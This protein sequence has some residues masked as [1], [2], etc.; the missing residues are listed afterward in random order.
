MKRYRLFQNI[1]LLTAMSFALVSCFKDELVGS[2]VNSRSN[3]IG[4]GIS[5]V[6][7]AD[8]TPL[9]RATQYADSALLML[10]RG[11]ADTLYLHA[12]SENNISALDT[13]VATRGVPVNSSNFS[14][15]CK[16]FSVSAFTPTEDYYMKN[17]KVDNLAN[18][19][20]S[21][22]EEHFWPEDEEMTL[23]F[24]A[25]A[26]AV[27]GEN[28][29]FAEDDIQ[30]KPSDSNGKIMSFD[31]TVP[32][33][34]ESVTNAAELQ[35]D[36]MFAYSSQNKK[37]TDPAT[38]SVP[39]KFYH[40]LAGVKFVAK[41]ITGGTVKSIT[42][43]NL[44]GTGTC[45]YTFTTGSDEPSIVWTDLDGQDRSFSQEFNV[46]VTNQQ[47]GE[48]DITDKNPETTFMMIPQN[49]ENAI[50]EILFNDGKTDYTLT[51]K[52]F[53]PS[54]LST[55]GDDDL[56]TWDAGKIYTYAISTESIN[57]T[58]VF[59][60]TPSITLPLGTTTGQYTVTSYR[61]RKGDPS[62]REAV[63]WK[64]ENT[65]YSEKDKENGSSV[66][67]TLDKILSDF[68]YQDENPSETEKS[69]S[70]EVTT[71]TLK[72]TYDGDLTL[73]RNTQRGSADSPYD[74]STH[75]EKGSDIAQTTANCYVVSAAGTYQLPLVYGN[76]IK[77]GSNNSAA[78]QGFKDYLDRAISSPRIT[79]ANNA[80][81]VWSDGFF[82][83]KDIHLDA[84]KQNLVFT[85]DSNYMQQ[86]NAVLAVR[87][88]NN[89][90]MWSWHIWVT[91]RPVYTK[92]HTLQDLF[93]SSN[94]YVLMQCNLGWVDGKMVYYNQRD[95]T[96]RFTQAGSGETAE[97]KV[98]QEGATFDYKDVG[99]TYYQWGRKDPLVALKNWD[100]YRYEDYRLHETGDPDYVYQVETG[101]TTIGNAIQ[102]PNVF[103]TRGTAGGADWNNEH[104]TTLWNARDNGGTLASITSVKTIYD[105]SPRGFKVP[106]PRAF[107]IFVGGNTGDGSSSS[108]K[109]ELNGHIYED[110]VHNKYRVYPRANQYK[111]EEIPLTATGQ[112]AD[113]VG[114]P[115]YEEYGPLKS[116]VGG[117]WSL[118]GVYYWTCVPKNTTSAYTLVIRKDY[119]SG[120]EVYS[121]G[122]VGT[123]TMA[124]PVRP[125]RE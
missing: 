113:V 96:F 62:I 42:L 85:I 46:Q 24:F 122:F 54:R 120:L 102:H 17:V 22:D 88:A 9:T 98:R 73:K 52:L 27:F 55:E 33:S 82:M 83:F 81:L 50:V 105:P 37:D 101:P 104:I 49:I 3:I 100:S 123:K 31:Y 7:T 87:D 124:R 30:Y 61:Q 53:D 119:P 112:R 95:L 66:E 106:I 65:S 59:E 44:S 116:E 43:K 68:T 58:Y 11:G 76:A 78:Y 23:D 115:V 90:I 1:G 47:T 84:S 97:L 77:N 121:Y 118:Y 34:G 80:V 39:L 16:N 51:G 93:N 21:S 8:G 32:G 108:G 48:Q 91:E 36:I 56:K 14:T 69:Y 89:R 29:V 45:T 38:G 13:S 10:G 25:Y 12:S 72:T 20:W 67:T 99:S 117:L 19:I 60:V 79:G 71:T 15:V 41:D 92:I 4:F 18:G 70:L 5:A 35:P 2:R 64:A 74:L 40:A 28:P 107:A 110:D 114:L 103:Y 26:P 86:A 109:G 94:T 111:E 125:I 57:W 63:A 75:D 6:T